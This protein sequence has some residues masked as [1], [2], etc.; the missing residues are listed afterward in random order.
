MRPAGVPE[1]DVPSATADPAAYVRRLAELA[2]GLDAMSELAATTVRARQ[3][4]AHL[5]DHLVGVEPEPGEWPAA[6][7]VG[8]LFDV[9]IV[10]GFRWRLVLTETDPVY[11]GYDEA[12][13]ATLPRLPFWQT[14]DA[15][16]S[17][18][19]ANLVLLGAMSEADTRR[20]GR[21][22]EQGGETVAVMVTKVVGH[23]KAHLNQLYRAIRAVRLA[24][25]LDTVELDAVY[26]GLFAEQAPAYA[27]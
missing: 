14:V 18:R 19:A 20:T 1:L 7:V 25:G 23:D 3:L 10:Y 8:H 6:M 24:D 15:W 16:E 21:H 22:G 26:E 4:C 27:H 11:P 13:W 2:D 9:D 17:L 12:E 5:P